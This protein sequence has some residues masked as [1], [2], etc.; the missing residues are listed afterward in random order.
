VDIDAKLVIDGCQQRQL[1]SVYNF[2]MLCVHMGISPLSS[3]FF[4]FC[5]GFIDCPSMQFDWTTDDDR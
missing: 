3:L 5:L 2:H 1:I 4:F